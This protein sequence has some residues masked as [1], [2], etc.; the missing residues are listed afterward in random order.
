VLKIAVILLMVCVLWRWALGKW[1]W[2]MLSGP[3][4]RSDRL[5]EARKLLGVRRV[6]TRQDILAAHRARVAAVHPDRGGTA[7]AVHEANAARDLLL[8]ELPPAPKP[9]GEAG[10]S[11]EGPSDVRVDPVPDPDQEKPHD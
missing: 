6:A 11:A 4:T 7:D 3:S 2:Q 1:P 9:S 8:T 10:E 5:R